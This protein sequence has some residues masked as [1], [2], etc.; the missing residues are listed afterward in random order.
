MVRALL[1]SSSAC[2]SLSSLMPAMARL[3]YAYA[4]N[5]AAAVTTAAA[6]AAKQSDA[7]RV[8]QVSLLALSRLEALVALLTLA[9]RL[10]TAL[11]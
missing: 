10:H 11:H 9:L 1:Q 4:R 5:F 3:Q 6:A 2:C 8:V 7:A